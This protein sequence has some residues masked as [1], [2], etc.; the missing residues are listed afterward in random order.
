MAHNIWI[1]SF[2]YLSIIIYITKTMSAGDTV[3]SDL[4][5]NFICSTKFTYTH[6]KNTIMSA[7]ILICS[8]VIF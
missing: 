6:Y 4:P 5:Y 8:V 2:L 3:M 7:V 1:S